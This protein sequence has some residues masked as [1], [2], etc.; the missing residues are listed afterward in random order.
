MSGVKIEVHDNCIH[1]R[2]ILAGKDND[3][4]MLS[5]YTVGVGV[6]DGIEAHALNIS[7]LALK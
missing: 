3:G 2:L 1:R 4:I 5:D 7:I 6:A